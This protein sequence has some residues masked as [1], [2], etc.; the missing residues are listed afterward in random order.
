VKGKEEKEKREMKCL[1]GFGE[2]LSCWECRSDETAT[3][4]CMKDPQKLK[5]AL[6]YDP[7]IPLLVILKKIGS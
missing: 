3:E 4:N 1:L 5:I 2:I 7:A 6:L